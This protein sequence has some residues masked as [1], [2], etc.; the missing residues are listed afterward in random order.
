VSAGF[1]AWLCAPQCHPDHLAVG[2]TLGRHQGVSVHVH[3][4]RDL[5]VPHQ[6]LP[7]EIAGVQG[8][9]LAQAP[10]QVVVELISF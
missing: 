3:R 9:R 1:F 2:L 7:G 8:I 10:Q 5:G 6:F 4:G